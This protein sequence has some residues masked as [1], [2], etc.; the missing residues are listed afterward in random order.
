MYEVPKPQTSAH[1]THITHASAPRRASS[2]PVQGEERSIAFGP[3]Y[4]GNGDSQK[5]CLLALYPTCTYGLPLVLGVL[6]VLG[7]LRVLGE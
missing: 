4:L 3:S 2:N 7:V 6:G 5:V 1:C